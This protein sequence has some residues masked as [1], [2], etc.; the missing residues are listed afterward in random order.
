MANKIFLLVLLVAVVYCASAQPLGTECGVNEVFDTCA[1]ACEPT[2]RNP[3]PDVCVLKCV[4]G[5]RCE[6]GYMK[7]DQGECVLARNC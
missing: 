1:S 7:N 2:C 3:T 4:M 6:E 5:C